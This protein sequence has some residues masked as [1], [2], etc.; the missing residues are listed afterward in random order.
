MNIFFS[1]TV[2][3]G[4]GNT[5]VNKLLSALNIPEMTWHTFQTHEK[6]VGK[7]VE[8][9]AYESCL[10]AALEKR[11]LTIENANKMKDLL[12]MI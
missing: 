5:Y 4:L 6:E 8:E 9:S 3:G 7:V 1:G 10:A 12:Q 11:R 2:N